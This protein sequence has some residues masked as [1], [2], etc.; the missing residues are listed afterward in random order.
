[1][2]SDGEIRGSISRAAWRGWTRN[3]GVVLKVTG[4]GLLVRAIAWTPALLPA[5]TKNKFPLWLGLILCVAL[6]VLLVLPQRCWGGEKLRR[7]FYTRNL[8]DR[9]RNVWRKWLKADLLRFLRGVA[10][11]LPFLFCVGYF[12]YGYQVLAFTKMWQP[13]M[14]LATVF[15][16]EPTMDMGLPI[17][18]GLVVFFGL[19]FAY[20]WWRNVMFEYLPIRSLEMGQA[21]RW[22]RR[23]RRH[24]RGQLA[25]NT[26]VNALLSL[27]AVAGVMAVLIPYVMEKVDF[28][29]STDLVVQL[30]MRLLSTPLPRKQVLLLAAVGAVL[31]LPLCVFRKTRNAALAAR[32]IKGRDGSHHEQHAA[33]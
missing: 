19:L 24:H 1:M 17:A 25:G 3:G 8:P 5:L 31:Y 16:R 9:P 18:G 27:P 28:S 21:F 33:G 12:V 11:G 10:W 2:S 29:L 30:L 4:A 13:V 32:L 7:I 14:H 22:A 26:A 15:G 23:M 6:H 20:G